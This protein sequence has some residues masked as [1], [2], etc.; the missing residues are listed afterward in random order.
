M[1]VYRYAE[2]EDDWIPGDGGYIVNVSLYRVAGLEP[3][4]GQ[5]RIYLGGSFVAGPAFR[6]NALFWGHPYG[7]ATLTRMIGIVDGWSAA[8]GGDVFVESR[9]SWGGRLW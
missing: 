7:A 4:W 5:H 1:L 2:G 8:T 3:R 6:N 9:R